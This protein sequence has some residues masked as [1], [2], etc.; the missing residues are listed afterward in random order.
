MSGIS[1]DV[2]NARAILSKIDAAAE[3]YRAHVQEA[4]ALLEELETCWAGPSGVE[5]RAKLSAWAKQQEKIGTGIQNAA[6]EVRSQLNRLEENDAAL[7][8]AISGE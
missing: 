8:D 6:S 1:V 2:E 5:V 4:N 7:A 3:A